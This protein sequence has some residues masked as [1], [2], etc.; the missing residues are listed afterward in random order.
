M[1][2][3]IYDHSKNYTCQVIK[4][5]NKIP[6]KGLD[7]LVEVNVQ[8]NSCLIGKDSPENELYLFFPAECEISDAFLKM[9]NLYRH[10][11]LNIDP[12]QKGFFEDNRRVKAIKFRGIISS[13]FVIPISSLFNL[14]EIKFSLDQIDN[15][16]IKS[17]P[18]GSEFNEIDGVEIC[19]KYVKRRNP[20][21]TGFDNPRTSRIE[22]II[23]SKQ[24]PEHMDTAHLM[25]NIH[26]LT[27]NTPIKITYKLHGTSARTFYTLAK[28]KL[29][30]KDRIA[31]FF[32]VKV[33]E[34]QYE[35][36]AASRRQLKSVGFEELPDK[37]HYYTDGDLWSEWAKNNLEGKLHKGEAVYYEIIGKTYTGQEIQGGYSY[38]YDKPTGYIYRISNIN[39]QGIEV[40][41]TDEQM[42]Q[43][44]Y[45]LCIATAPY[46]FKGTVRQFIE[47][48]KPGSIKSDS[49]DVAPL[50]EDIFY[51]QLLDKPSIFDNKVVEEGFCVRVDGYPKPQIFKIKS[52]IFLA[53]ETKA[54]DKEVVDMEEEQS[55]T[56]EDGKIDSN[57]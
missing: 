48:Y 56:I 51:N 43:R 21:K 33:I 5:P 49:D 7:N 52:K 9:N 44:A 20:G 46:F 3:K 55:Q 11:T 32:G 15:K 29:S 35:Y 57:I 19:K 31:K 34:E 50:I 36:V 40:D 10:E 41:L 18:I 13:G 2:L 1:S 8:G 16:T 30:W 22:S 14:S 23:D 38:N 45:D 27:I 6:V 26:K 25:K 37:N 39:P 54:L 47:K 17:L 53:N 28:R 24:A 4:L 42:E 12:T